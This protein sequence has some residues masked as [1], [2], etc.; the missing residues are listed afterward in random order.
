MRALIDALSV[1]ALALAL[2]WLGPIALD[3]RGPAYSSYGH[4]EQDASADA[5]DA[6]RTADQRQCEAQAGP[7]SVAVQLP[8]GQHRCADKH[9]RLLRS[10]LL[11]SK[12]EVSQ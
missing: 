4:V 10:T 12:R 2:G 5:V 11:A 8:D 6:S 1:T 9:G 3:S 7:H